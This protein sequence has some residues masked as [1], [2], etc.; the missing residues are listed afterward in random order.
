MVPFLD[1][2]ISLHCSLKLRGSIESFYEG[3]EQSVSSWR[4]DRVALRTLFL[5][6]FR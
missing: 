4:V 5:L 2:K 6:N 1:L 3:G